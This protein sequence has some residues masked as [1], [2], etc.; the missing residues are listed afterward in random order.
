MVLWSNWD[1]A[2][3]RRMESEKLIFF[4]ST[5]AAVML[6][7]EPPAAAKLPSYP[8]FSQS[9]RHKVAIFEVGYWQYRIV[10]CRL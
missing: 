7:T 2:E 3:P 8:I 1:E 4:T 5:P 10:S 9:G 6:K